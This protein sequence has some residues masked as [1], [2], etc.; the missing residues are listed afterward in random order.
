M[1][2]KDITLGKSHETKTHQLYL[3][4]IRE[5][6]KKPYSENTTHVGMKVLKE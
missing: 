2:E 4:T 6:V 1:K 5:K 3:C